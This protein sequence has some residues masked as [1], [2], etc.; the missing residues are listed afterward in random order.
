MFNAMKNRF[1]LSFTKQQLQMIIPLPASLFFSL[2]K[3]D[4]DQKNVYVTK[5][6]RLLCRRI[7]SV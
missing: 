6:Q 1:L 3:L 2:L 4:Q 5:K 7:C